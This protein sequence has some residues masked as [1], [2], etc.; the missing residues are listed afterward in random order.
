MVGCDH[1]G[2]TDQQAKL[3]AVWEN[4]HIAGICSQMPNLAYLSA[5]VA[6]ARDLTT[7]SRTD[8]E[9]LD[10]FARET[11][12]GCCAGCGR[13]FQAAGSGKAPVNDVMRC[14]VHCRD[15]GGRELTREVFARLLDEN[16]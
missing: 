4:P 11:R 3:K 7:R 9:M 1:R 2:F 14:L 12:L 13:I 8:R 16:Q 10:R 5:N 15:Y 6:A